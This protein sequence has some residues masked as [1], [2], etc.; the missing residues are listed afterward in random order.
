MVVTS[1]GNV[2][3]GFDALGDNRVVTGPLSPLCIRYG[4]DLINDLDP[5]G[6]RAPDYGS[7]ITP[8][9]Q[10]YRDPFLKTHLDDCLGRNWQV[11]PS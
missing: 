3:A 8:E 10:E 9:G 2:T 1:P 4:A 5:C 7:W 6:V 11:G